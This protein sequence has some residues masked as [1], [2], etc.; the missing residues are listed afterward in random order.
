[1]QSS[2]VGARIRQ[3]RRTIG[4]TQAEL[5]RRIG[6]SPSYLNLIEWN[7]RR[8]ASSLLR[9][10]ADALA[11]PLN[12]F[13]SGSER[14]LM[15]A[16]IGLSGHPKLRSLGIE[17]DRINELIARFPGWANALDTLAHS[18]RDATTRVKALSEQLSNDPYLGATLHRMLTRIAAV[19]STT[20]ILTEYDDLPDERRSRFN[21]I[22]HEEVEA[23]SD[24][25]EALAT[26]LERTNQSDQ[27]LTPIDEVEA[28]YTAR[29]NHFQEIEE[30]A[31]PLADSLGASSSIPLR[32]QARDL[33]ERHLSD[34]I[35][36][37]VTQQPEIETAAARNRAQQALLTYAVGAILMPIDAFA[38]R[39]AATRYDIEV[40][41]E[42]FSAGAEAV[43]RRLTTLPAGESLPRFGYFQ[44]NAAGTI[45]AMAGL[46]GL[47]IPRYAAACPLWALYRAQ[48][49]PE[50]VFRQ[51]VLFP[52]GDRFVF[53]ARARSVGPSGFGKPRHYVTDM[54]ALKETDARLTVYDPEP[55]A[56]VE[57]VGPS[58][59]LCPRNTCRHRVQD[60]WAE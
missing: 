52:S 59:R 21:H 25:G 14:Q 46:E 20:E 42:L 26:Y 5:A 23:L 31:G 50:T 33:A 30:A 45:T 37:L 35:D 6:I 16:L 27:I 40:L 1:M 10:I 53:V 54:I 22:V 18:E 60:P 9:K 19:R 58:C 49:S 2:L 48:Q 44:A 47:S 41:A 13:D 51:R 29:Q 12:E 32:Q 56:T 28:L 34:V 7:K 11:L 3:T 55:S 24:V 39:A 57:E 8:V 36:G 15:K 4:L 17:S 43:C 38:E